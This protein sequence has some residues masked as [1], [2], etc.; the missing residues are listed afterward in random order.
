MQLLCAAI[1][2][3]LRLKKENQ[4]HLKNEILQNLIINKTKNEILYKTKSEQ[5]F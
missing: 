2:I 1:G 3:F 4:M 5:H